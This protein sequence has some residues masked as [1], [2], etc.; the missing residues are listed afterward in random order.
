[1][2]T[3]THT[4]FSSPAERAVGPRLPAL[5]HAV[6][7]LADKQRLLER[8]DAELQHAGVGVVQAV[9]FFVVVFF[10]V[11]C[12]GV[13]ASHVRARRRRLVCVCAA[14]PPD[15]TSWARQ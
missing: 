4:N 5:D 6:A 2:H 1:M 15:A 13:C 14:A 9:C 3:H 10:W 12:C 7:P 11:L 8:R